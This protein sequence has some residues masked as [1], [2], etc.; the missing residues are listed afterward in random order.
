[1]SSEDNNNNNAAGDATADTAQ[2]FDMEDKEEERVST[3]R[4]TLNRLQSDASENKTHSVPHEKVRTLKRKGSFSERTMEGLKNKT[5]MDWLETFI[6]LAKWI[7]TYDWRNYFAKDA[8]AG[9]TVGVMIIPQSMSY[10]KLAGLPVEYGLY[11]GLVPVYAYALFGSSRQLAVGPVALV[12]LLLSTGLTDILSE[13]NLDVK[14]PEYIEIYTKMAIQVAFL[15][16]LMYIAMGILRLGFVTIFLS[17]TVV[18]GFTTGA[19]VIIGMSQVKHIVGYDYPKSDVLHKNIENIVDGI[20]GFNY[21]TFL[22]GVC[23]IF[24]LV[25]IKWFSGTDKKYKWV[26]PLGPLFVT[27]ITIIVTWSLSLDENGIPIVKKIP[28]GLPSI[29]LSDWTPIEDFSKIIVLVISITIV[30]FMESIAIAKQLAAK[31]KYDLDSSLEL[32]GLG[33]A[34]FLGAMFGAYPVTGSFSRS[35]VNNE[36]GAVSGMSGVV[37][38]TLVAIVLLLLTPVFEQ[39]V[40][41]TLLGLRISAFPRQLAYPLLS[42]FLSSSL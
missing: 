18:S 11:S 32:I 37:T 9:A 17:H 39:L 22:M 12:S 20:E 10:A 19:S 23:S 35:A 24:A 40:C 31:H 29:T 41:G 34:N 25:G 2:V 5:P 8:I 33:M 7:K 14:S 4:R 38:A 3:H 1:M 6:P 16:G 13:R 26:A 36:T 42:F 27:A 15:V 30:G 28:K 21:K